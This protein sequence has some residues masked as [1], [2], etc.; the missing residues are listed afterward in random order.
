MDL[1]D[2]SH[3]VRQKGFA[4]TT[5]HNGSAGLSGWS[6]GG[7]EGQRG[8]VGGVRSSVGP[9]AVGR[10]GGVGHAT[11]RSAGARR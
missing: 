2:L 7:Y 5:L 1:R 3:T 10:P 11:T 6:H 8:S 4:T 9:A